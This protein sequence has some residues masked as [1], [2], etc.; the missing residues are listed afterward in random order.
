MLRLEKSNASGE[1]VVYSVSH[2]SPKKSSRNA[3][4]SIAKGN[5]HE[6]RRLE[7][8]VMVGLITLEVRSKR[9]VFGLKG[10]G[11]EAGLADSFK[12]S[13]DIWCGG[14]RKKELGSRRVEILIRRDRAGSAMEESIV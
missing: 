1:G 2:V 8:V 13:D 6:L 12:N 14:G 4:L 5:S 3:S 9:G 11:I 7:N 10:V